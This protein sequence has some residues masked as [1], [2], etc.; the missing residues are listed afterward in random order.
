MMGDTLIH[1]NIRPQ[2]FKS[3]CLMHHTCKCF[4]M[5]PPKNYFPSWKGF[6]NKKYMQSWRACNQ[7]PS[8]FCLHQKTDH[9]LKPKPTMRKTSFSCPR[10]WH[11]KHV[12]FEIWNNEIQKNKHIMVGNTQNWYRRGID[13]DRIVTIMIRVIQF[14]SSCWSWYVWWKKICS[15]SQAVHPSKYNICGLL[16]P[17]NILIVNT[18][19]HIW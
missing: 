4:R 19:I 9:S 5:Y 6:L 1:A 14:P 7:P 16:S 8:P 17:K 12:V 11:Q 2:R 15:C 10:I 13:T 3:W 18:Y